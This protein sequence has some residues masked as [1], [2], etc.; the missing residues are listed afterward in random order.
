MIRVRAP[1]LP[2]NL[3]WLN[4]DRPLSLLALQGR[5]VI[6][7]FWTVSC[8][9]CLHVIPD[10]KYLEQK[11]RD[12]LVVI[13][14]HTA[15]FDHEQHPD[16]IQQAIVR[17]GITHPVVVDCDRQ[18]WDNYTVRA[19]PTFVVIA[20]GYVVATVSGEGKRQ[21]LDD[22]IQQLIGEEAGTLDDALPLTLEPSPVLTYP[23]AF[24]S[25]VLADETSDTLFIADTGHH[26]IAIATLNGSE[27]IIIGTGKPGWKDGDWETAQFSA[28]QG[29][30]FDHQQQALFVAD[31]GNHLLRRIDL[32]QQQVSTIAGTG[33]QSRALFPHCGKALSTALNSPWDLVQI[34]E[35]LYIAMSGSHQIWAM[36]LAQWTIQTFTGT[37]AE[38]CVDG[39]PEVAAFAQPS[40]ITTN[41]YELFVADSETSSI[42]AITLEK[43]PI[44]RTVCGSGQLFRF[45]DRDGVGFDAQ[46]QHCLGIIYIEGYLWV[47]DTY[48]HKIKRVNPTTGDCQT[49][50]GDGKP[51]F[52]DG[53]GTN[54]LFAEPS[55]L[56]YIYN[57]LYVADTNNHAIRQINLK[58]LE[59]TTL[60]F[61]TLC[62][63]FVCT[64]INQ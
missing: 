43:V 3:P 15:K 63:P 51:G 7:E 42:R 37:G 53:V 1:E 60:Q 34:G 57:Y 8:I 31:T 58:S 46:M 50:C 38:F 14:V 44:A 17:Y 4:C 55:G 21:F 49:V 24:P 41:G 12:R 25:I 10:V 39:S 20:K 36:D 61:P 48:N 47:A 18:I 27:S 40:G 26:R 64:P 23:L 16:N 19:W 59:V 35:V 13:G 32:L 2:Q 45:G 5:I 62:S 28:P 6:L 33:T 22:L 29:M 9:N 54:A 52:Q 30:A 56:S 11:Y